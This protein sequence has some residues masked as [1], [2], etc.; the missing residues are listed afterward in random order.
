[1]PQPYRKL[2]PQDEADIR[3]AYEQGA[4][5][6]SLAKQYGISHMTISRSVERAGGQTRETGRPRRFTEEQCHAMRREY[7]AGAT[8]RYLAVVYGGH[9]SNIGDAIK[10]VGGTLRGRQGMTD[11]SS[12][13]GLMAWLNS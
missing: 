7:E 1:M 10:R 6:K 4:S 5:L 11:K 9:F 12:R 3:K 8:L 2:T 13:Q